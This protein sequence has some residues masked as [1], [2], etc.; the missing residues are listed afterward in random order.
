MLPVR[1]VQASFV[2][3]LLLVLASVLACSLLP[4]DVAAFTHVRRVTETRSPAGLNSIHVANLLGSVTVEQAEGESIEI[5]ASF[6]GGGSTEPDAREMAERLS[7]SLRQEGPVLSVRTEFP[8]DDVQ[9][10]VDPRAPKSRGF[11]D[12]LFSSSRESV[13]VSYAGQEVHIDK[14]GTSRG[15]LL[16][17]DLL[18]RIPPGI[19]IRIE[20][21]VGEIHAM[22]IAASATLGGQDG[23][24]HARRTEGTVSISLDTG[25]LR[26]IDGRGRVEIAAREAACEIVRFSGDVISKT[27]GGFVEVRESSGGLVTIETEGGGI[28]LRDVSASVEART[29]SGTIEGELLRSGERFIA[30]SGSGSIRIAGDFAD[31][32]AVTLR[33]T[34]GLVELALS[35]TPP[36]SVAA[37]T[38][39]GT[40]DMKHPGVRV[41]TESPGRFEGLLGSGKGSIDLRSESGTVRLLEIVKL[42]PSTPTRM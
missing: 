37:S 7:L 42:Y 40:L 30:L 17:A 5:V 13:T 9:D 22:G 29:D 28:S 21:A 20:N 25:L 10:Y 1:R 19:D 2:I 36:I 3:A 41:V 26:A 6:A 27:K 11:G 4:G 32:T 34:S 14:S 8:V 23:E 18:I 12:V 39:R 16:Y 15:A 33:S 24:I 31:A 35:E 38:E